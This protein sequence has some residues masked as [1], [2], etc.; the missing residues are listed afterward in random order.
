MF[1]CQ[2]Q[3]LSAFLT[4]HNFFLLL[5]C[6]VSF[7]C[8]RSSQTHRAAGGHV[9]CARQL[10]HHSQRA[11]A[12]L[13]QAARG[14]RPLG[15]SQSR[16]R[17]SVSVVWEGECISDTSRGA[18]L[19]GCDDIVQIRKMV[20][21]QTTTLLGLPIQGPPCIIDSGHGASSTCAGDDV[22]RTLPHLGSSGGT[23]RKKDEG[24]KAGGDTY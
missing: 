23:Q 9:G 10:Q 16:C 3:Q 5:L 12:F 4:A 6:P 1:F 17:P 21:G 20:R 2:L 22:R 8:L 13:Q 7:L 15:E 18:A 19:R 24:R 14:E 11:E